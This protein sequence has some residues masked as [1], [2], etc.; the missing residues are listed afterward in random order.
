M[1][2]LPELLLETLALVL[3]KDLPKLMENMMETSSS[4]MDIQ[5]IV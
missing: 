2:D 3:A 4:S 5:H 1:L